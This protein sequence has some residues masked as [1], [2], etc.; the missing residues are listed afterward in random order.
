MTGGLHDALAVVG[1][2]PA[3]SGTLVTSGLLTSTETLRAER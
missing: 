1:V 2:G 3:S